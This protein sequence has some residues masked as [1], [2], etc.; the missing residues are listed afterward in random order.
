MGSGLIRENGLSVGFG[1]GLL[2]TPAYT[3]ALLNG[4]HQAC[5]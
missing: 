4:D 5:Q 1:W 3:N 2:V